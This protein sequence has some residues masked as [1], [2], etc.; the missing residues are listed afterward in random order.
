MLAIAPFYIA[1]ISPDFRFVRVIY[2]FRIFR[3]FKIGRYSRAMGIFR[4]VFSEKKEELVIALFTVMLL[5]IISSGLMFY[6]ENDAQPEKFSSIPRT[7]WWAVAA[8]TTVGYGDI[9]PV[10]PLGRVLGSLI[11]ILGVGLFALP[12][13]ILASGFAEEISRKGP[14]TTHCPH[15]GKE[16]KVGKDQ[17]H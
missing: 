6:T 16:I 9:F 15:C 10:T 14:E 11:A 5:L 7:M 3:L 17:E 12:A 13:G 2:L 1:L 4:N 8:L